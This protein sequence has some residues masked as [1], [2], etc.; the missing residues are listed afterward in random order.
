VE[1]MVNVLSVWAGWLAL[2]ISRRSENMR[3]RE[4]DRASFL[5][6]TVACPSDDVGL[7][8]STLSCFGWSRPVF[9]SCVLDQRLGGPKGERGTTFEQLFGGGRSDVWEGSS[10]SLR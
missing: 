7:D 1:D 3:W 5:L 4:R 6:R 8:R 10:S 2:G 9:Y